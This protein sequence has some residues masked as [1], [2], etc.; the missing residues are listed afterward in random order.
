[1]AIPVEARGFARSIIDHPE[2]RANL[3]ARATRGVLPPGVETMLW[4]YAF[5]KPPDKVD[6]SVSDTTI[7]QLREMSEEELAARA[8]SIATEIMAAKVAA[9]R[10][11]AE[12]RRDDFDTSFL[13]DPDPPALDDNVLPFKPH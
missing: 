1:M 8:N 6:V 5:G 13:R 10:V 12:N 2:Y 11:E 9:A 3:L 4:H 7:S